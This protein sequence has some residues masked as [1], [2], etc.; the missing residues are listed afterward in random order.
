MRLSVLSFTHLLALGEKKKKEHSDW[1]IGKTDWL[2]NINKISERPENK[3]RRNVEGISLTRVGFID[4]IITLRVLGSLLF[5]ARSLSRFLCVQCRYCLA[6]I[7][8]SVYLFVS[9]CLCLFRCRRRG[10]VVAGQPARSKKSSVLPSKEP[11]HETVLP[12]SPWGASE[13]ILA[14]GNPKGS[15]GDPRDPSGNS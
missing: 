6:F 9:L 5:I 2:N 15:L 3:N 11:G 10:A 12:G 1:Q 7:S 14:K 13:G 4:S 8:L